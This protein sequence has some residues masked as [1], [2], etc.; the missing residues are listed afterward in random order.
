[1]LYRP[2]GFCLYKTAF[3][4]AWDTPAT[5]TA[6]RHESQE[7]PFRRLRAPLPDAISREGIL[8]IA[9]DAGG[10]QPQVAGVPGVFGLRAPCVGRLEHRPPTPYA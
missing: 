8:E 1:M 2:S 6:R 7:L 10:E 5:R 4:T 3:V 9:V